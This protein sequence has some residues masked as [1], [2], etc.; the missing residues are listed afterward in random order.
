M[1]LGIILILYYVM[2]NI[3]WFP[4]S[5]RNSSQ[6][7]IYPPTEI[8][9]QPKYSLDVSETQRA[10]EKPILQSGTASQDN[11]PNTTKTQEQ[12]PRNN[13][14]I[15][16]WE[17]DN[18]QK[19]LGSHQAS[20]STFKA[21]QDFKE[22][23]SNDGRES[24]ENIQYGSKYSSVAQS[25]Y[26]TISQ[27][28][29]VYDPS[30]SIKQPGINQFKS[31]Q[32]KSMDIF[33]SSANNAHNKYPKRQYSA[34]N[35]YH[36]GNDGILDGQDNM[37]WSEGQS[38]NQPIQETAQYGNSSMAGHQ[39]SGLK[40]QLHQSDSYQYST[41]TNTNQNDEVDYIPQYSSHTINNSGASRQGPTRGT[42]SSVYS[43]LKKGS[44]QPA[45]NSSV[46]QQSQQST[47]SGKATYSSVYT[48]I[49]R[50]P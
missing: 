18:E 39:K 7:N 43:S 8:Y 46:N 5:G 37:F 50:L 33:Q 14:K 31:F 48:N 24:S 15:Y 10:I 26:D 42:Y 38:T 23:Y 4:G 40:K 1:F 12:S 11:F 36:Q 13:K 17:L 2:I 19:Q 9:N 41:A 32:G 30:N 6:R 44:D 22:A 34:S 47:H 27:Q 49:Q 25:N 20:K 21:L 35:I 45:T 29:F 3:N 28:K 16:A